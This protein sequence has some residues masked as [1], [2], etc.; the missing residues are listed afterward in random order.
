MRYKLAED[1]RPQA[2]LLAIATIATVA[3]W[4]IPYAEY[5]VY[6]IRLFVTFIHEAGHALAALLTGGSVQS[7]TIASDGSGVVYSAPASLFGALFTSSAGYLGTMIFGVLMLFLMRK[8]VGPQKV[9]FSLGIFVGLVTLV[10]GVIFPFFNLFSLNVGFSSLA[11]T[12]I[13]GLLLAVGLGAL[14]LYGT[15]RITR[16]AVAFLAIQCLMNAFSDL[17]T[18]FFINAPLVGMDNIQSDAGNM[19]AATG[20]PAFVWTVVWILLSMGVLLLGFRMFTAARAAS[21]TES[22]FVD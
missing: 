21:P 14:A 18:L 20:I 7:L 16:F 10:F 17:K 2:R 22:V 1:A 11:F 6:P 5:L 4:F 8:N 19:A 12:V 13:A 15:E 3:L 9:L